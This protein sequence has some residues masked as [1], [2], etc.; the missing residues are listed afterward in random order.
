MQ[1]LAAAKAFLCAVSI[2]GAS[3]TITCPA[4]AWVHGNGSTNCPYG[5]GLP[6][7][8]PAANASSTT[9]F[10]ISHLI[11][12]GQVWTSAHPPSWNL[13]GIDYPDGAYNAHIDPTNNAN[14]PAGCAFNSG[15]DQVECGGGA[16][17]NV[18]GN[19]TW[20]DM[21]QSLHNGVRLHVYGT[22]NGTCTFT[23]DKAVN[24]SSSD[25]SNGDLIRIDNG[26]TCNVVASYMT[27]DGN[28]QN[29][30]N[31]LSSLVTDL[32]QGNYNTAWTYSAFFR[33]TGKMITGGPAGTNTVK[34]SY[35]EE[36]NNGPS[37]NHGEFDLAPGNN[38]TVTLYSVTYT[39]FLQ[40]AAANASGSGGTTSHIYSA[41]GGSTFTSFIADHDTF[42]SNTK[43]GV[44]PNGFATMSVAS[45]ELY[46]GDTYVNGAMTN[47]FIDPTGALLCWYPQPSSGTFTVSGNKNLLNGENLND[48]G[49]TCTGAAVH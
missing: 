43:S 48:W 17:S 5:T 32:R 42:V 21:D 9:Q 26:N 38:A 24:G 46:S 11:Q 29:F 19:F 2:V 34:Y 7:G 47:S 45:V 16:G 18:G 22:Y 13:S 10:A 4:A 33:T 1:L 15:N 49:A 12:S 31:N 40:T 27:L 28:D 23:D 35:V 44:H 20:Q 39:T 3:L 36:Y 14:L 25:V 37:G 41:G 8:C 6:D 30:P